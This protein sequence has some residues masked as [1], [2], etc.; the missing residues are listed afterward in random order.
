[1]RHLS[2]ASDCL[3]LVK[4]QGAVTLVGLVHIGF[5]Q[6]QGSAACSLQVLSG[7]CV[8]QPGGNLLRYGLGTK[9]KIQI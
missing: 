4:G 2:E 1:M 8:C 7:W 9:V 6:V 5:Q 3:I